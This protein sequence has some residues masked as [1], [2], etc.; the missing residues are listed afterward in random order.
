MKEPKRRNEMIG[1]DGYF[2]EYSIDEFQD[3]SYGMFTGEAAIHVYIESGEYKGYK[4]SVM[5]KRS[6]HE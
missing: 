5:K 6:L 4:I 3:K 2:P 1:Y